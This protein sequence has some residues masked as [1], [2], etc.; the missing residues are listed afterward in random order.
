M[1]SVAL[2][3]PTP[4]DEASVLARLCAQ[5]QWHLHHSF[6]RYSH[7]TLG[8]QAMLRPYLADFAG[9]QAAVDAIRDHDT[10][11]REVVGALVAITEAPGSRASPERRRPRELTCK[12]ELSPEP[13]TTSLQ[14]RN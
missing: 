11:L 9:I 8:G 6:D 5:I 13:L 2:R 12:E 1:D 4:D 3:P 7:E 10:R 14:W